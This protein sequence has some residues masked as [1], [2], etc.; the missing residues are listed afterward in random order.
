[1]GCYQCTL[2][3]TSPYYYQIQHQLGVTGK[4][5]GYIF[6]YISNDYH[7]EKIDF[8]RSLWADMEDK[9]IFF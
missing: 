6:V 4:E 7:L 5:Y 3:K 2:K 8:D 1:M 9:F